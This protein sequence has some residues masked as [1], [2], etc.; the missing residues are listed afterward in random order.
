MDELSKILKKEID[1]HFHYYFEKSIKNGDLLK[2]RTNSLIYSTIYS[3]HTMIMSSLS[4]SFESSLGTLFDKL[5][6]RVSEYY[7]GNSFTEIKLDNGEKLKVDLGFERDNVISIFEN[8]LHGEL[9]NKKAE[10]EK[11]KLVER[12]E[13]LKM[14]N[15]TKDIK[16][17]L[18]VVGNKN[19]GEPSNWE[20]GRVGDW[21]SNDEIKVEKDLYTYVSGNCDFFPWFIQEILPYIGKNYC[22]LEQKVYI[23]YNKN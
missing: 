7:N 9:D 20:K 21:F 16:F 1:D 23:I 5:L 22:E 19:G 11:T 2:G 3:I 6:N 10:I 13:A 17:F 14:I 15:P 8:K 4:R 18:G 12:Y